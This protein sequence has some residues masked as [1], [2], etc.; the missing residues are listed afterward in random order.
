MSSNAAATYLPETSTDDATAR[1]APSEVPTAF[2]T[3][4]SLRGSL[5]QAGYRVETVS[6]GNVPFLR[7][8]SSGLAFDVRLGNGYPGPAGQFAD[9]VFVALFAV[10][11]TFPLEL[12]NKWNRTHRFGRLFLDKVGPDQEFLVL[13]FDVS[14]AGGVTPLHLRGQIEIWD[15]LVQQL[16][17]WLRE[18]LSKIAPTIDTPSDAAGTSTSSAGQIPST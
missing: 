2:I 3:L 6:D 11:G 17:P 14:V 15:S 7:S 8:A 16:I 5:Q 9:A 18:E 12:L 10:R 1:P 4:D 13:S